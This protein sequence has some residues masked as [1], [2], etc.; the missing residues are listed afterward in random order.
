MKQR[1]KDFKK[2][3][4][5]KRITRLSEA[6]SL[7]SRYIQLY[8]KDEISDSKLRTLSYACKTYAEISKIQYLEDLENRLTELENKAKNERN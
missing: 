6:Q 7:L 3:R 4:A 8:E 5:S 2:N 1:V